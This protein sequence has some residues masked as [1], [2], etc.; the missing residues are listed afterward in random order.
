M[1]R[2]K[3]TLDIGLSRVIKDY[4]FPNINVE[5]SYLGD[6]NGQRDENTKNFEAESKIVYIGFVTFVYVNAAANMWLNRK[7]TEYFLAEMV[8]IMILILIPTISLARVVVLDSP[9]LGKIF[10]GKYIKLG[11]L[12][13]GWFKR[14]IDRAK[15]AR[16]LFHKCLPFFK[17]V[18]KRSLLIMRIMPSGMDSQLIKAVKASAYAL[19]STCQRY[20]A[21]QVAMLVVLLLEFV[22]IVA[23]LMKMI[24]INIDAGMSLGEFPEPAMAAH[25]WNF[26]MLFAI[27]VVAI[28]L[29]RRICV[30]EKALFVLAMQ[31]RSELKKAIKLHGSKKVKVPKSK[32]KS[33]SKTSNEDVGQ[34]TSKMY[35]TCTKLKIWWH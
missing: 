31:M 21:L 15:F 7:D 4:L 19:L 26:G 16:I 20:V 18:N 1:N 11:G 30:Q 10:K 13:A 14:N 12:N 28:F 32:S 24:Y 2:S 17:T 3:K 9:M 25:L 29:H 23:V 22:L 5:A 33:V 27:S 35:A 6:L 8:S 34:F